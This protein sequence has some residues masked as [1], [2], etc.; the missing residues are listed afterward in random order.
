MDLTVK[1]L[2]YT[3]KNPI[4]IGSSGLTNTV[5]KIKKLAENN[6]GA[7]VLKS[8]FEEQIE[9]EATHQYVDYGISEAYDYI[10]QYSKSFNV[11][12]YLRLI[13]ESRKA[14]D[15]PV[16]ASINAVSKGEW[17]SYAKKVEAAG[18][19]GIEVNIGILPADIEVDGKQLEDLHIEILQ[20]IRKEVSIPVAVKIS[21]YVGSI[22]HL[23]RQ[24][25]WTK[26]ADS[27]VMFNRFYNPD[28]DL[29]KLEVVSSNVFSHAEDMM[30]SLRWIALLAEKFEKI[31][32]VGTT[33]VY[34]GEDVVKQMLVGADAV[35]VVSA[36]YKHGEGYINTLLAQMR[37]WMKEKHFG[38]I[39]DFK[40]KMS[41]SQI[42][43]PNVF[44]RIQF[45]KYYGTIE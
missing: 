20:E 27:V 25:A 16:I 19:N 4:I 32:F 12:K 36:I 11:D 22:A 31:Q 23:V 29:K 21:P 9:Q 35:E 8:L 7:V 1:Y 42:K 34:T 43:N 45:M 3:L 10:Q 30:P 39:Y 33:G 40:G 6:A 14:V 37:D 15:I 38:S 5:G 18:A 28:I 17:V 24:I 26:S 41:M 13:E 44:E 2:G